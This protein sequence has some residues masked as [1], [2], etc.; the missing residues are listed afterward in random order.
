MAEWIPC[1]KK[2]PKE[3]EL[4]WVTIKGHDV[5]MPS[6]GESL[7]DAIIRIGKIRRVD[8][9]FIGSDGWYGRDGY[10]MIV[11]PIAW[12]KMDVPKP[13]KGEC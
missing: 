1:S 10:P 5:I 8:I 12:M 4:V 9:G 6:D 7:E 11:T 3:G 2:P 13:Y